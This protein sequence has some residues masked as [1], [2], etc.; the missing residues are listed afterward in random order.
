MQ[1]GIEEERA[2]EMWSEAKLEIQAHM[3]T[4]TWHDAYCDIDTKFSEATL[5]AHQHPFSPS[6]DTVFPYFRQDDGTGVGIHIA[7]NIVITTMY[8]NFFKSVWLP[9]TVQTIADFT[10]ARDVS[11]E[12]K[13]KLLARL[14]EIHLLQY[15]TPYIRSKRLRL[16]P[17]EVAFEARHEEWKY[18]VSRDTEDEELLRRF[19]AHQSNSWKSPGPD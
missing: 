5:S 18:G 12:S 10:A 6:V 2:N 8:L 17:S 13:T 7:G 14:D 3:G 4:D 11:P 15:K 9:A 1:R 19:T 16:E